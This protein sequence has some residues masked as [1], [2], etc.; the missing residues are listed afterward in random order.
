MS[1]DTLSD[2]ILAFMIEYGRITVDTE[3][4]PKNNPMKREA[5]TKAEKAQKNY[6][7]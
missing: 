3:K 7:T 2:K 4:N 6:S 5:Y 1:K